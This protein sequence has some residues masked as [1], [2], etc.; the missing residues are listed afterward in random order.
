MGGGADLI[1]GDLDNGHYQPREEI[2]RG[3]MGVVYLAWDRRLEK[4]VAIKVLHSGAVTD[5]LARDAFR[6]EANFLG[7][8]DQTRI[9]RIQDL[10]THDGRNVIVMEYVSGE[11]LDERLKKGPR[12]RTV[13]SASARRRTSSSSLRT[14]GTNAASYFR[15]CTAVADRLPP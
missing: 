7:M 6:K 15:H 14:A 8:L 10:F 4:L 1:L 13:N 12:S 5:E 2:G 3:A 11:S 9:A